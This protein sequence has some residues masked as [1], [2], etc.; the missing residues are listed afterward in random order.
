MKKAPLLLASTLT[1]AFACSAV[2]QS[3]RRWGSAIDG[4]F[5]GAGNQWNVV[6]GVSDVARFSNYDANAAFTVTFGGNVT[7]SYFRVDADGDFASNPFTVTLDLAGYTYTLGSA[8]D[9][10]VIARN[11]DNNASVHLTG[12]GTVNAIHT[13]IGNL[14]TSTGKLTLSGSTKLITSGSTQIG[15]YGSGTLEITD[16]SRV[17]SST[18]TYVG[19]RENS[20]GNVLITGADSTWSTTRSIL[21]GFGANSTSSLKIEN[22]GRLENTSTGS[23]GSIDFGTAAGSNI[24]VDIKG[25]GSTL[26]TG[27]SLYVGGG[28][29]TGAAGQAQITLEEGG[30]LSVSAALYLYKQGTLTV[31]DT[32]SRI[33][34]RNLG[35]VEGGD[36]P[37]IA[38]ATGTIS[39][40]LGASGEAAFIRASQGVYL[41]S[42]ESIL[43]LT[44]GEGVDYEANDIVRLISYGTLSGTFSN[45]TQGQLVTLGTQQFLFSYTM[46]G[47]SD[48]FIGLTAVPEPSTAMLGLFGLVGA[49]MLHKRLSG[50]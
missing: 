17:E 5:S 7:N 19:R 30:A 44:L 4:P 29:T 40:T 24:L 22:G 43:T 37:V 41:D 10:N 13:T 46:G 20:T 18:L 36:A 2:A 15:A 39:L 38:A 27:G 1:L 26:S 45:Y 6:P 12:H 14:A 34:V 49:A 3:T 8:T 42:A 21:F 28:R 9:P 32:Q 33:T 11:A 16:A 47:A 23:N 50:N 35:L 48:Q 25:V 31:K